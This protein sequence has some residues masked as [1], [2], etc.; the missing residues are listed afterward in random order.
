MSITFLKPILH[1]KNVCYIEKSL[2]LFRGKVSYS[3]FWI[4]SSRP[5]RFQYNL[6]KS[7][8]KGLGRLGQ[9]S[10]PVWAYEPGLGPCLKLTTST[11]YQWDCQHFVNFLLW[12]KANDNFLKVCYIFKCLLHLVDVSDLWKKLE[13]DKKNS[14]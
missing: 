12:L 4:Q 8:A 10:Q 2:A 1:L 14:K 9:M 7:K 11:Y 3:V 13:E 6:Q 5:A